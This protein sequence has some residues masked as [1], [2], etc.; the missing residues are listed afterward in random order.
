MD[1]VGHKKC[2][3]CKAEKPLELFDRQRAGGGRRAE[4]MDCRRHRAALWRKN[5]KDK[6]LAQRKRNYALHADYYKANAKKWREDNP[7]RMR[8]QNRIQYAKQD[9]VKELARARDWKRANRAKLSQ[10]DR[11][12][13]QANKEKIREIT[14]RM[15]V[16]RSR[17]AVSWANKDA[18][19]LRYA[20]AI[21]KTQETG[22][23]HEVDHIVP[24][25]SGI[26][27]G[28]HCEANLQVLPRSTNRSKANRHW[29]GMP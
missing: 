2:S 29:P 16:A 27:C 20:E 25:I 1:G 5:N 24:I 4:C 18:M 11:S 28:L 14:R 15:Q 12:Y 3:K 6:V 10:S 13:R 26:V 17:A 9:K 19:R 21:R 22:I 8:E 23:P 7:E